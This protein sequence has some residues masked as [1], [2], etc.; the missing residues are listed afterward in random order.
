MGEDVSNLF[1]ILSDSSMS[2]SFY[3][4][5]FK[6]KQT[7]VKSTLYHNVQNNSEVETSF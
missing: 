4:N 6:S 7:K 2:Q 1:F 5:L 3:A